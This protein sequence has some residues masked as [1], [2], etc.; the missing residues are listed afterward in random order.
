LIRNVNL[1]LKYLW[2]FSFA[3]HQMFRR[4]SSKHYK[5]LKFKLTFVLFC[6]WKAT[7]Q[8]QCSFYFHY[9][10]YGIVIWYDVDIVSAV[11]RRRLILSLA[12]QTELIVFYFVYIWRSWKE[13]QV[14]ILIFASVNHCLRVF[15]PLFDWSWE[16]TLQNQNWKKQKIENHA[17]WLFVVK[18]N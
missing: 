3:R 13:K 8:Q 2:C 18:S 4:S 9:F 15:W 17:I 7:Q 16:K 14:K 10:E 12:L 1:N 5:C 6:P 11:K